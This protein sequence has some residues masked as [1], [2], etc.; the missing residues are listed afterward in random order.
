VLGGLLGLLV[1]QLIATAR[2]CTCRPFIAEYMVLA[3]STIER[4]DGG[5]V[6]EAEFARWEGYT[7]ATAGPGGDVYLQI[8]KP[9]GALNI[10]TTPTEEGR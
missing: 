6:A 4:V 10:H 8:D 9:D 2:A 3:V 5:D 1:P 7:D